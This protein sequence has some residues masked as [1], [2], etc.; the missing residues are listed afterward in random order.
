MTD[1]YKTIQEPITEILFKEK[2]SKFIGYAYPIEHENEVKPLIEQL[3]KEH[4]Q[5][6]HVCYAYQIGVKNIYYRANDDGEPNNTAG[7][8]I[9]GQIKSFELTNVLV[10]VVRYFGGTKLGVGG[11]IQAY[12]TS[13]KE[14]LEQAIIIQKEILQ[15]LYIEFEYPNMNK[16][17]RVIHE[18]HLVILNQN[19]EMNCQMTLGVKEIL[20]PKILEAVQLIVTKVKIIDYSA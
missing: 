8:P 7:I 5:A 17:M 19:Q 11:L 4:H 13:A 1:F 3:K 6:R 15:K 14:T 10:V 12:K 20:I 18:N 9:L 16:I 2:G